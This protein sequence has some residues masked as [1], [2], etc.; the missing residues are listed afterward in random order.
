MRTL[1]DSSETGRLFLWGYKIKELIILGM[2][3]SAWLCPFDT[4]VWGLNM[5]WKLVQ[6]D[7]HKLDKLFLAHKQV[8]S[9]EGN[10]FFDWEEINKQEIDVVSLHRV[11]GLKATVFPLKRISEKF[12]TNY[13]SDTVC[14][15]I[16]YAIDKS[17]DNELKLKEDA[18][19]KLR[20]YG[21]D[22]LEE[23]EYRHEKGGIEFWLGL[24]KGIGIGCEI[25]PTSEVLSTITGKPYGLGGKIKG[26]GAKGLARMRGG[27]FC[28]A[29]NIVGDITKLT[30]KDLIDQLGG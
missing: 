27:E 14:Y 3:P 5:G 29:F 30:S 12:Q 25:S 16:A 21:V 15:M 18:Y 22:M 6:Q 1:A 23:E 26:I 7:G 10:P 19:T 9:K 20:L 2:G 13:F 4:E 24:A 8:Y 17:T 11:R 28:G